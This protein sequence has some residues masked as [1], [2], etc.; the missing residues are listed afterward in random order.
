MTILWE[1]IEHE[2]NRELIFNLH[3]IKGYKK[4]VGRRNKWPIKTYQKLF[5][6]TSKQGNTW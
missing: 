2:T 5:D 3:T 6:L 1:I 4:V